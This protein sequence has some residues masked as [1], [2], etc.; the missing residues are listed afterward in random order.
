MFTNQHS[1]SEAPA[2][3]RSWIEIN[4]SNL[5]HNALVL[6]GAMPAG[7]RLMAVV[8]ADGYGH[9]AVRV[10]SCLEQSGVTAFAVATWEEGA[11]LRQAGISGKILVLGYTPVS[12][13]PQLHRY[14]LIQTLIDGGYARALDR[15][16]FPLQAHLKVDTGMH[17]LGVSWQDPGEAAS[18]FFLENL[19]ISGLYTH[20]ASPDSLEERDTA[21]TLGQIRRFYSLTRGLQARGIPLPKLHIQSSYG[22]LNYPQ[23]RCDYVRAGIA[24]YGVPSSVSSSTRLKLDLRPVLA[25]KSR[26]ILLRDV[27]KGDSVGYGG[28]FVAK[29]DSR[30]AILPLGYADGVPR[31]T[32]EGK[33]LVE[34]RGRVFPIAGRICMDQL[35]VDV[36]GTPEIA[37]G[38]TATIL[39][40]NADSPLLVS[41]AA[42][43]AGTIS[44]EFLSRLGKR[45]PVLESSDLDR[46]ASL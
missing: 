29:R 39:A 16:G 30:I 18:L 7:C 40:G 35:A 12:R 36:T 27:P 23:L 1:F 19:T 6:Q 13:A 11:R 46:V 17:R 45:L 31:S 15:Q 24:L 33:G 25:L 37:P 3:E 20:L 14:S 4:Y 34:I 8:K 43:R 21:F 42:D 10:S 28:A 41:K 26:V 22:L 32:G 44:N 9:G 38:D 2:R 5:T